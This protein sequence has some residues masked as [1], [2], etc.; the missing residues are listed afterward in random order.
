LKTLSH[1]LKAAPLFAIALT[2]SPALPSFAQSGESTVVY[3]SSGDVVVKT[4]DGKL[5]NYTTPSG[6]MVSVGGKQVSASGLKPGTKIS[7]ALPGDPKPV[8]GISVE[9]GK[10]YQV[11]PPDKVTL[12]LAQGIKELS[13]PAGTTFTVGGKPVSVGQLQKGMEVTATVVT[14]GA[15]A[16]T[17]LAT[18]P[19]SG[20]IL[21]AVDASVAGESTLPEAGT[22]LPLFGVL[23]FFSILLGLGMRSKTLARSK[24]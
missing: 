24:S 12:T 13:V 4:A 14:V 19:Q 11:D 9:T 22:N 23:G 16:S 21:L 8:S 5:L 18:P 17:T 1:Y 10:V 6:T 3:V 7:S 15:A 2:L 20:A